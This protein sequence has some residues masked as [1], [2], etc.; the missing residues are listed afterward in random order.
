[1]PLLGVPPDV[2][3]FWTGTHQQEFMGIPATGRTVSVNGVVIDRVVGGQM[4]ESR[5]LMN[6][7]RRLDAPLHRRAQPDRSARR[8]RDRPRQPTPLLGQHPRPV[9]TAL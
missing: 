4:T 2:R 5:M 7:L 1:V 3:F 9:R 8:A 6:S